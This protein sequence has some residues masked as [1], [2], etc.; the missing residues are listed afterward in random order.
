MTKSIVYVVSFENCFIGIPAHAAYSRKENYLKI[1]YRTLLHSSLCRLILFRNSM[2]KL[3]NLS[4]RW[5]FGSFVCKTWLT[6][7]V[8]C[9]TASILNLCAIALDRYD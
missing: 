5:V 2:T 1:V 4:S 6:F 8:L 3:N 9:C 7:D